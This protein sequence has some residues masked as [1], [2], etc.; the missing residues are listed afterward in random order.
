MASVEPQHQENIFLLTG[1]RVQGKRDLYTEGRASIKRGWTIHAYKHTNETLPVIA[2]FFMHARKYILLGNL[3][4]ANAPL[5][6]E[7]SE[8]GRGYFSLPLVS[9]TVFLRPK[10]PLQR[11][12]VFLRRARRVERARSAFIITQC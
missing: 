7:K 9:C 4:R 8:Q 6:R 3:F 10:D 12:K 11:H 1:N 2:R 5:Q